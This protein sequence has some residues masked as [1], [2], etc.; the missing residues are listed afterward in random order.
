M[1]TTL[2]TIGYR[3][4]PD[5]DL[6]LPADAPKR[7]WLAVRSEG[8]GASDVSPI[9]ELELE[10]GVYG[11]RYKVWK[12]KVEDPQDFDFGRDHPIHVGN[13]ME[14]VLR[15]EL[16]ERLETEIHVPGLYVCKRNPVLRFT[17]DGLHWDPEL[18]EW[19]L[20]EFKNNGGW[21]GIKLWA[22]G[23]TPAHPL[24]QVQ[25]AMHASGIRHAIIFALAGGNSFQRRDVEYD[26][27]IGEFLEEQVM[28]FWNDY[29][30]TRREPDPTA[31]SLELLNETFRVADPE[32]KPVQI[33]ADLARSLSDE[34][35]SASREAKLAKAKFDG[36]NARIKA[37]AGTSSEI[38]G[39]DGELLFTVNNDSTLRTKAIQDEA[40]ELWEEYQVEKKV[41]DTERFKTEKP[42]DHRR[43]RAR[44]VKYKGE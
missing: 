30:L 38:V 17:P 18:G 7:E 39:P 3:T 34:H 6:V 36:V 1:T 5:A 43:F 2:P 32:A 44:S 13:V 41:F 19:V 8:I 23:N 35:Q 24:A 28:E 14:P 25:Y 26:P 20:D 10:P 9:L 12:S 40:P 29:V 15:Q 42:E 11:D 31:L 4:L 33:D 22:D 21:Q 27:E 37:L 16:S